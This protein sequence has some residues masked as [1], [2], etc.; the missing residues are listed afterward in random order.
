MHKPIDTSHH[1]NSAAG[2]WRRDAGIDRQKPSKPYISAKGRTSSSSRGTVNSA[3][4]RPRQPQVSS[5]SST[6]D[7]TTLL[8][9]FKETF[10][11]AS[12]ER[13]RRVIFGY[14]PRPKPPQDTRPIPP[15]DKIRVVS[16]FERQF[17]AAAHVHLINHFMCR[18]LG[19]ESEARGAFSSFFAEINRQIAEDRALGPGK[20]T[21][22]PNPNIVNPE[23]VSN[24]IDKAMDCLEP[25]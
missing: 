5:E 22:K 18:A 15:E 13:A 9:T 7:S 2:S 19:Y 17:T 11:A 6:A 1:A 21:N 16:P 20:S 23:N 4:S 14:T 25:I 8:Q 3:G 12:I 24:I 10:N